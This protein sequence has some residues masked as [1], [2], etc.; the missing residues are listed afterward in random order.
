MDNIKKTSLIAKKYNIP[1]IID[2]ARFCE[3]A[4]F[5]K[6]RELD[7]INSS[8]ESIVLKMFSYADVMLMSS[9]KDALVNIGGLCCVKNNE[10][11]YKKFVRGVYHLKDSLLMV[12]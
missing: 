8:I 5:I 2:C 11:L 1:L 7:Y 6:T 12:V 10:E 9:K 4:Y 3:N